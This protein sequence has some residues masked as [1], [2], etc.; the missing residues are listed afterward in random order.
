MEEVD[1]TSAVVAEEQP[2]QKIL[3]EVA[4]APVDAQQATA[5]AAAPA[6]ASSSSAP[7]ATDK[8]NYVRVVAVFGYL[9]TR[10]QGLQK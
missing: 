1:N 7:T 5:D 8:R 2:E 3:G 6:A 4:A 10:F 9:G